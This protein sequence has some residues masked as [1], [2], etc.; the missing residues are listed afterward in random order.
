MR[1]V[2]KY[3]HRELSMYLQQLPFTL[4]NTV[5]MIH[6]YNTHGHNKICTNIVIHE[7]LTAQYNNNCKKVLQQ[8]LINKITI[9][10]LGGSITF[11]KAL[12]EIR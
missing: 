7:L 2:L 4:N 9:H 6:K 11:L 5:L 10:S 8:S 12:A 3:I 1:D